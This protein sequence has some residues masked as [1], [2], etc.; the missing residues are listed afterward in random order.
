L[1]LCKS[2]IRITSRLLFERIKESETKPNCLGTEKEFVE[3]LGEEP[4]AT[5]QYPLKH[6]KRNS[7]DVI[8]AVYCFIY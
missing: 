6:E 1:S 2:C 4:A 5:A 7:M 8:I 3:T